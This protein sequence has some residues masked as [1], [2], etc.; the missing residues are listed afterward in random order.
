MGVRWWDGRGIVGVGEGA[1]LSGLIVG[2]CG[3]AGARWA[4]EFLVG[5]EAVDDVLGEVEGG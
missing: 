2:D 4:G 3:G 5:L 1:E